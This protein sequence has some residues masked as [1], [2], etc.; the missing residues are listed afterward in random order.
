METKYEI[1][2]KV[3]FNNGTNTDK[4]NFLQET[5]SFSGYMRLHEIVEKIQNK[6]KATCNITG[7]KF[8]RVEILQT[9]INDKGD[10]S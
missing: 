7:W 8:I 6:G 3:F 1:T 5:S 9:H 2:Y 10:H 4:E